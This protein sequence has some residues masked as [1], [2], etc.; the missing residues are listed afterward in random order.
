MSGSGSDDDRE[1]QVY[2]SVSRRRAESNDDKPAGSMILAVSVIVVGILALGALV[3][4]I[5]LPAVY[6]HRNVSSDITKFI[7]P[8][9][10]I[11]GSVGVLFAC[12]LAYHTYQKP[13]SDAD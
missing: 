6:I 4:M 11:S 13:D 9:L 1:Q 10:I 12:V 2:D 7:C 5:V 3:V 8:S